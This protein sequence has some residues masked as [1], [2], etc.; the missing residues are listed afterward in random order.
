MLE[1]EAVVVSCPLPHMDPINIHGP[2][3]AGAKDHEQMRA[4]KVPPG[5]AMRA[6]QDIIVIEADTAGYPTEIRWY[7]SWNLDF[8][9]WTE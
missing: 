5:I 2:A 1:E 7:A 3:D 9:Y 4:F 6:H 8:G